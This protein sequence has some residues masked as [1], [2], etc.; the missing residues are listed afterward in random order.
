MDARGVDQAPTV[1]TLTLRTLARHP[2]RVAFAWDGGQL[3][4]DGAAG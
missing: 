3:R 1:A 2:H 4:Y